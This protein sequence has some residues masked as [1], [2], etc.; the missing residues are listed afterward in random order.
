MLEP[1]RISV[2][3][4][5]GPFLDVK[6]AATLIMQL[7]L[8]LLTVN[9]SSKRWGWVVVGGGGGGG[10]ITVSESEHKDTE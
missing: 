6:R 7:G 10:V 1:Q 5:N 8:T 9:N 4:H 2:L 3:E